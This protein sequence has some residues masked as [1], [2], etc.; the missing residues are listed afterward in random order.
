ML[1]I[2]KKCGFET[3]AGKIE[4]SMQSRRMERVEEIGLR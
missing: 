2:E 4:S 1:L 3:A